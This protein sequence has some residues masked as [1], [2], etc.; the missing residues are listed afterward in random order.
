MFALSR[1]GVIEDQVF[2]FLWRRRVTG[3]FKV[4][5]RHNTVL[6][7]SKNT[8]LFQRQNDVMWDDD[9]RRRDVA[10]IQN[11]GKNLICLPFELNKDHN[12][13]FSGF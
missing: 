12:I 13:I 3:K 2:N 4:V 7:P 5:P 1:L 6:Y 8:T 11:K 10:H 9:I